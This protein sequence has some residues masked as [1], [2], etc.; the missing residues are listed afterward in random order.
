MILRAEDQRTP[1]PVDW[2]YRWLPFDASTVAGGLGRDPIV[3]A[4][5]PCGAADDLVRTRS[6]LYRGRFEVLRNSPRQ[7]ILL[8]PTEPRRHFSR[9]AGSSMSFLL[10][11]TH[12]FLSNEL[13]AASLMNAPQIRPL[14]RLH[15]D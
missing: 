7:A 13:V 2:Y 6:G 4:L 14:P 12:L 9:R 3:A 1:R 5:D 8:I 15:R 10:K 11:L